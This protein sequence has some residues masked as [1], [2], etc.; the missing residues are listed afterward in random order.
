MD[1]EELAAYSPPGSPPGDKDSIVDQQEMR[2]QRH[3]TSKCT[4]SQAPSQRNPTFFVIRVTAIA[5]LGGILF[6]YD[7]G[8]IA[9]ALPLL[10]STFDLTE[11][12]EELCVSILYLGGGV[13]AALGGSLCDAYGRKRTILITDAIFAAGALMFLYAGSLRAIIVARVT[14]GFALALSGIADVTY[15]HEIAPVHIRGAIVSVNEACISLGFLLAFAAGALLSNSPNGWRVM[16]GL[17]GLVAVIQFMGMLSLPE[18][19]KWLKQCGRI[20]EYH[21]A[22]RMIHGEV[23]RIPPTTPVVD[24]SACPESPSKRRSTSSASLQGMLNPLETTELTCGYRLHAGWV[25]MKSMVQDYGMFI[26]ALA[27]DYRRQSI[28]ALFLAVS[29][30]ACGQA[31][32]LSYAPSIFQFF[33]ESNHWSYLAI[34][35]VKFLVTVLVIWKI[36]VLGR[37]F[38]LLAGLGTLTL[39]LLCMT[40]A[41]MSHL[42]EPTAA[43]ILVLPGVLLI[44]CGYS[45]SFGPLTWLLTSELFPTEI[46]GRALG[47][48]TIITY[49]CASLVTNT[50]LTAQAM[51]GPS[52]VFSVYLLITSLGLLFAWLAVPDTGGK[53]SEDIN[54]DIQ[55][56]PWWLH[57]EAHDKIAVEMSPGRNSS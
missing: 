10:Q 54:S 27:H 49:V 12:Q 56:M 18:S 9:G 42:G 20:E 57:R 29:Q 19:P 25:R 17:S 44:T 22:Y 48:S 31:N 37:R 4:P 55:T 23:E 51:M 36:D 53:T 7:L 52:V 35:I 13:G 32:V 26:I 14:V 46:R 41:Y 1:S 5:G 39:G 34:G 43:Q 11:R 38:L 50:Y 15:L 21:S 6:G 30:Q 33:G 40:I 47:I 2:T 8:V 45:M 28:I 3:A 24:E 16:F